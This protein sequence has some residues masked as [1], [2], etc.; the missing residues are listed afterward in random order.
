M[1][2]NQMLSFGAILFIFTLI[3]AP[4]AQAQTGCDICGP[5]IRGITQWGDGSSCSPI[6]FG[7]SASTRGDGQCE[8]MYHWTVVPNP[9]NSYIDPRSDDNQFVDIKFFENGTYTVC[10][11]LTTWFDA[12]G[13]GAQDPDEMCV[14]DPLC[15]EVTIT[16]CN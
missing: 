4:N 12:D 6:G 15:T 8:R 3:S 14:S 13:D 5:F 2:F 9:E 16:D 7:A 10:V 11:T 1:K